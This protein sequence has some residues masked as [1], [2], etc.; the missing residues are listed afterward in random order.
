M[1]RKAF[2][3]ALALIQASIR[4]VQPA[5]KPAAPVK[6]GKILVPV[7]KQVKEVIESLRMPC[8][9]VDVKGAGVLKEIVIVTDSSDYYLTVMVDGRIKYDRSWTW[10]NTYSDYI[11]DI[12]CFDNDGTY[13]LILLNIEYSK[14]LKIRARG[15]A[16]VQM[17]HYTI[18]EKL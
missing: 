9:I 6:P 5:V 2:Q 18:E 1:G 4:P 10:F 13:I 16:A 12:S 8:T 3:L 14:S 11:A 15:D 7:R 17:A